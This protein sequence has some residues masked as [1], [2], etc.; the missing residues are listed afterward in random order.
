MG[1]AYIHWR[2]SEKYICCSKLL[3][4]SGVGVSFQRHH[5]VISMS[6]ALLSSENPGAG[7]S[8]W[9]Y[10][11]TTAQIA[12]LI[13]LCAGWEQPACAQQNM[14]CLCFPR[15]WVADFTWAQMAPTPKTPDSRVSL[16]RLEAIRG[17]DGRVHKR[18]AG[19]THDAPLS[20]P[21]SFPHPGWLG[22]KCGSRV[23]FIW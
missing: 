6:R 7:G 11:L 16:R 22:G 2:A 19:R 4:S 17:P 20:A 9:K 13:T 23:S 12:D 8:I 21:F 14:P 10:P 3:F 18:D 5:C 15:E 1:E